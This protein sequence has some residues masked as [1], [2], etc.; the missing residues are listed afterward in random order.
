MRTHIATP[1]VHRPTQARCIRFG[2]AI[3]FI[4]GVS[5]AFAA[6]PDDMI[7]VYA[8][9]EPKTA[10]AGQ[11][12]RF[13][14]RTAGDPALECTISG[15]PGI[16]TGE[17]IGTY[18]FTASANLRAVVV[19]TG[20]TA[21]DPGSGSATLTVVPPGTPPT[22]TA[23][24]KPSRIFKGGSST[25]RW[26][27]TLATDCSSTGAV[28]ISGTS[29]TRTITATSSQTVTIT[30]SNAGA[31]ASKT[32]TLTAVDPPP[33]VRA[34]FT[35]SIL[36]GPG[37]ATFEWVASNAT[38]CNRGP[39]HGRETSYYAMS[40]TQSVTCYGP[41]GTDTAFAA[42]IVDTA[43]ITSNA[44]KGAD[45]QLA[46]LGFDTTAPD[47]LSTIHDFNGDGYPDA[48]VID[49]QVGEGYVILG[50]PPGQARIAKVIP[51]VHTLD[52]V[53][54]I[55]IGGKNRDAITVEI[56]Q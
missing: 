39:V 50:G 28:S 6:P 4:L 16:T 27:S 29:G 52:Q 8:K 53:K 41:G 3:L 46:L 14:W 45:A 17:D 54:N 56:S 37:F 51:N 31:S 40:T 47:T 34:S 7:L 38:S 2:C 5:P 22:V 42:V 13:S 9:F 15:V 35:P 43:T 36:N 30:C 26:S 23:E 21:A 49:T 10:L 25:L 11:P 33:Q 24:F 55:T 20:P 19:C 18:T 1:L 32:V 44:P 48:F 12:V